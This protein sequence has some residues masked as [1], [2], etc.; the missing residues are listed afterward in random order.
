M[1]QWRKYFPQPKTPQ[2]TAM[3]QVL[4][5]ATVLGGIALLTDKRLVVSRANGERSVAMHSVG[6]VDVGYQRSARRIGVGI[7]LIAFAILLFGVAGHISG[8]LTA[9]VQ[10]LDSA[11]RAEGSEP[12]AAV[13]IGTQAQRGIAGV[14]VAARWLPWLAAALFIWGALRIAVGIWGVTAV[15]VSTIVGDYRL[16]SRG[17]SPHLDELGREMARRSG[18]PQR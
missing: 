10:S 13:A 15:E 5:Q 1:M 8:F 14:A 12:S 6:A 11:L 2:L 16:E 3:E 17:R 9:Q 7:L 4:A 18:E